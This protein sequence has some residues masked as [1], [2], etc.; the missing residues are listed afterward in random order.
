MEKY[1]NIVFGS[2]SLIGV[3]ISKYLNIKKTIFTS[4][5]FLKNKRKINWKKIDLNRD[6]LKV[7]PKKI[8]K[9]FFLAS[10]YYNKKNLNNPKIFEDEFKWI[11]KILNHFEFD[12]IIYVSSSSVY[13]KESDI[14][15]VKI[16]I[17]NFLKK[18]KI[19]YLQIWRPF[20]LVGANNHKIS[21]HFHNLLLKNRKNFLMFNGNP[22]SKRGYS[23][24]EKFA[25][26]IF[27]QSKLKKSFVLNYRNKNM[28][29]VINIVKIYNKIL[30]EK[31]KK[32][33]KFEF[34]KM[35]DKKKYITNLKDDLVVKTI[36]SREKSEKVLIK[37]FIENLQK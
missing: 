33:L 5:K 28:L 22:N 19:K 12:Q 27:N 18:K 37:Y 8:E 15:K 26:T 7:L 6:S 17:E 11:K 32:I 4:R 30:K 9:I 3:E 14:G 21:D 34:K 24:V 20:N 10:P 13:Y 23:S 35:N 31:R 29:K 36:Y 25:L 16:K 2:S 1:K